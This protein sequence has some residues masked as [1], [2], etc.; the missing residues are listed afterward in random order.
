MPGVSLY[1]AV[2]ADS[3]GSPP[4][5]PKFLGSWITVIV[6]WRSRSAPGTSVAPQAQ[7][8]RGWPSVSYCLAASWPSQPLIERR[9]GAPASPTPADPQQAEPGGAQAP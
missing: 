7:P 5:K 4:V 2:T 8:V 3:T 1:S 6:A 9:G